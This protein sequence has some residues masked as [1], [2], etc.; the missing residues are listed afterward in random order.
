MSTAPSQWATWANALSAFRFCSIPAT[1][2]SIL[3]ADWWLAAVLF[4][5]AVITD[6]YDGKV[7]RSLNQSSPL[8][9]LVDHAT[10]A[11]F[12]SACHAAFAT[13]GVI[14]PYLWP[15]I[16]LS[17]TQYMLDSKALAGQPLRASRIGRLNGISYFALAGV[18]IGAHALGWQWLVV[19]AGWF[20]WLLVATSVLSMGDRAWALWRLK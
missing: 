10:D 16:L 15:L 6:I 7:A 11:L 19:L 3:G 13:M 18:L 9:G 1:A 2:F 20:A 8:G 4:T 5:L 17:F 14:N 12:V